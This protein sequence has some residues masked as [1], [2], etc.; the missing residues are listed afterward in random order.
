[1][2]KVMIGILVLIPIIIVLIVG[3]VTSFV[4]TQTYIGVD[5]VV[6]GAES[7]N[8]N[9]S[10]IEPDGRGNRILDLSDGK[11]L[12]VQV[13]PERATNRTVTWEIDGEIVP[14]MDDEIAG[15]ADNFAYFVDDGNNKVSSNTTGRLLVNAYCQ[16]TVTARAEQ[17]SAQCLITVTDDDVQSVKITWQNDGEHSVSTGDSVRLGAQYTP[18]N[19]VVTEGK[20]ESDNP[21][22]AKVDA[23]GIV[24]GVSEGVANIT[25]TAYN[26]DGEPVVSAPFEVTVTAGLTKFGDTVVTHERTLSLTDLG[27]SSLPVN[28]RGVN[29]TVAEGRIVIDDGAERAE[30]ETADGTVVFVMCAENGIAIEN[31]DFFRYDGTESDATFIVATDDMPLVLTA[32]WQSETKKGVPEVEWT[33]SA[34]EIAAVAPDGS[35]TAGKDGEVTV[36]ARTADGAEAS[37]RLL[38]ARKLAMVNLQITDASLKVG[39]ARETVFASQEVG[40]DDSGMKEEYV[41]NSVEFVTLFPNAPAADASEA[42]KAE[43]YNAFVFSVD[44]PELASFGEAGTAESN[45]LTFNPAA[46][47][48]K[49][50]IRVTV[51][52]KHKKYQNMPGMTSKSVDLTVVPGVAVKNHEEL[53]KAAED[54]RYFRDYVETAPDGT[55]LWKTEIKTQTVFNIVLGGDIEVDRDTHPYHPDPV[56]ADNGQPYEITIACNLYGNNHKIYSNEACMRYVSETYCDGGQPFLFVQRGDDTVISNVTLSANDDIGDEITSGGQSKGLKGYSLQCLQG[57]REIKDDGTYDGSAIGNHNRNVRIE[58]SIIQNASSAMGITNCDTTIY[59][60]IIRNTTGVGIYIPTRMGADG[61]TDFSVVTTENV[62]MSNMIGTGMNF[63]FNGFDNGSNTDLVNRALEEDRIS[64][65]VQK[66]FLDI[67]NW[68]QLDALSLLDK[69]TIDETLSKIIEPV[70]QA[71]GNALKD[72]QFDYIVQPYNG[73]PNVH[74]GFISTGLMSKS[75]FKPTF[76]GQPERFKLLTSEMLPGN[77]IIIAVVR[78]MPPIYIYCYGSDEKEIVPG[79]VYT[80]ESFIARLYE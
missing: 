40:Y 14:L 76:E 30:V 64:T 36:T 57:R 12:G 42:E 15:E 38:A 52:V 65:L 8:L 28:G 47:T 1:M 73:V 7:L 62:L 72:P 35:V 69:S 78:E 5:K 6:L 9:L 48:E 63:D 4:S 56:N 26:K 68:Q 13:L 44:K 45:V 58:Y 10:A 37:V 80:V 70:M 60:C 22:V 21:D 33:S 29:C 3:M 25:M 66:G 20:W 16:F 19:S 77:D 61:N 71:L 23:N 75:Y 79:S 46:I 27:F 11:I 24:T 2:K 39:I 34:P 53:L 32:V 74:F 17:N 43:F 54:S 55:K 51:E 49:T 59:G 50:V 31:A 41:P 67:Y 18:L